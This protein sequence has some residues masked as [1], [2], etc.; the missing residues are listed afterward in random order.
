MNGE[1][2]EVDFRGKI[3]RFVQLFRCLFFTLPANVEF[4]FVEITRVKKWLLKR[5]A[6]DSVK[7]YRS[8]GTEEVL[9]FQTSFFVCCAASLTAS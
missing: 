1:I 5:K 9:A 6:G 4:I 3:R 2:P 8:R 7:D